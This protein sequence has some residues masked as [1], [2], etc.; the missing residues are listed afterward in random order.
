MDVNLSCLVC[1]EVETRKH[2]VF[3]CRWIEPVWFEVLG[4]RLDSTNQMNTVQWL[5]S[6]RTE[7]GIQGTTWWTLCLL[8]CWH[9]WRTRCKVAFEAKQPNPAAVVTKV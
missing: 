1:G 8:T 4:I 9:I 2:M 6:R 7:S 3:K 5:E